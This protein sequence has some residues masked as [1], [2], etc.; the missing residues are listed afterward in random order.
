MSPDGQAHHYAGAPRAFHWGMAALILVALAIGVWAST[1]PPGTSPRR[2]LL[3]LHK[4]IGMTV[5]VLLP[6]RV[7][8]RWI[9]G[10]PGFRVRPSRL[11]GAAARA[12][13]LCLYALMLLMPL[14]GYVDSGAGGY[15]LPWFGLF[16]W[17]RLV[18]IDKPLS[19]L[20][21]EIHLWGA[22]AIGLLLAL[23]FLA[24]AWH[25]LVRRDEVLARMWPGRRARGAQSI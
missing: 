7:L 23:H 14:S 6:L 10:A 21:G 19:H 9:A 13:H 15:A 3:D 18:P 8:C 2:E 17:P 20:G 25:A 5:L 4:S 11:A 12:A 1:L 16:S 24:V 22:W